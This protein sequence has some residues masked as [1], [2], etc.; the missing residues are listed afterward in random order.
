MGAL[1]FCIKG[2]MYNRKTLCIMCINKNIY[3]QMKIEPNIK[4]KYLALFFM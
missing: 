3:T 4:L 1:A 2:I